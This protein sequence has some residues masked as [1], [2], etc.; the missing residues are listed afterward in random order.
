MSAIPLLGTYSRG[1][2]TKRHTNI[3]SSIF[4][5]ASGGRNLA[6]QWNGARQKCDLHRQLRRDL[7]SEII[8]TL[9]FAAAWRTQ[10]HT[11]SPKDK[12]RREHA[13]L[14]PIS[15][16]LKNVQLNLQQQRTYT[17]LSR[18]CYR[19]RIWPERGKREC[20]GVMGTSFALIIEGMGLCWCVY[21]PKFT[22]PYT[23][24][25]CCLWCGLYLNKLKTE[26]T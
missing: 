14:F 3:Y 18:A 21:F 6:M 23:V 16:I 20:S 4:K 12:D 13:V 9:I 8:D 1:V 2:E 10:N 19:R 11:L 15:D 5:A 22:E 25:G 7:C 24:N 17:W 26:M